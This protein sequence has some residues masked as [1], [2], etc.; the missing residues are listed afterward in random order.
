MLLVEGYDGFVGY[1][2]GRNPGQYP[3]LHLEAVPLHLPELPSHSRQQCQTG[4]HEAPDDSS[5]LGIL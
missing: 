2:V 5:F 4:F 3:Y 1:E